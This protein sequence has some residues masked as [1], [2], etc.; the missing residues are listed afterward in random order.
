MSRLAL[1]IRSQPARWAALLREEL[2]GLEVLEAPDGEETPFV[3]AGKPPPGAFAAIRGLRVI[4]SI[5]AGIEH[6]LAPGE[7]PES[8]TIVR[9][10]D[11]TLATGMRDWA[12]AQLLAWHRQLFL[13]REDSLRGAWTPRPERLAAERTVLVLGAGSLGALT[14]LG[15]AALGFRTRI[16]SRRR[17]ALPGIEAFAGEELAQ[18]AAGADAVISLLPLTPET[19]GVLGAP[20]FAQLRP[21][22]LLANGGRGA[23]VVEADLLAAL[24]TGQ[25]GFAA[26]DVFPQEPLPEAH[27]FWRHP[28]ILVSPHVAAPTH[29]A[30]AA[31]H[32]AANLRDH[33]AGAPLRDVVDRAQGY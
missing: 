28:R 5:N 32:I 31:R 10:S 3:V 26:L 24:E 4:F 25:L 7:V 22:A 12:L 6:L 13:Y 16:W 9:L 14:A 20:L 8:V 11:P 19:R 15:A 18:A 27:P 17:A 30:S 29:P 33:L 2:P 21:G 23:H 1:L